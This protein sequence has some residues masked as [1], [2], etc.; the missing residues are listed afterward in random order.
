MGGD[1][2]ADLSPGILAP[3]S[4]VPAVQGHS[5]NRDREQQRRRQQQSDREAEE[6]LTSDAGEMSPHQLDDMA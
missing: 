3:A 4:S 5:P 1:I 2:S 6:S